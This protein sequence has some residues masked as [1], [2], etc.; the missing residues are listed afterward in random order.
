MGKKK[1]NSH[2]QKSDLKILSGSFSNKYNVYLKVQKKSKPLTTYFFVE[3]EKEND[4]Q[5]SY[6]VVS[7][8][9]E[10]E[11]LSFL[12]N[13]SIGKEQLFGEE[14]NPYID[15]NIK[16]YSIKNFK[17]IDV[18]KQK[19]DKYG[20]LE[21]QIQSLI[22]QKAISPLLEKLV[23]FRDAL[24]LEL[25]DNEF[26]K[27]HDINLFDKLLKSF[28]NNNSDRNLSRVEQ[29][30]SDLEDIINFVNL[31]SDEVIRKILKEIK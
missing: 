24:A 2:L 14:C 19:Q 4:K 7:D 15:N 17:V 1:N 9:Y 16:D 10:S 28:E 8:K 20:L 12:F 27:E 5:D 26:F 13:S 6:L 31:V 11:Y 30:L 18:S 3:E 25:Y 22:E 21:K 23:D 29:D